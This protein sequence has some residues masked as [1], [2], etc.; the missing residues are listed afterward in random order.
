[1]FK[2]IEICFFNLVFVGYMFDKVKVK[3]RK[4][5]F[6]VCINCVIVYNVC[7]RNMIN[8]GFFYMLY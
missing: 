5:Q 1:M 7:Y 2:F 4:M 3:K 6:D 8:G